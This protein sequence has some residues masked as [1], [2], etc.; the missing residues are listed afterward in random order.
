MGF[1]PLQG[2][3]IELEYML[4]DSVTL[5]V[6]PL[7]DKIFTEFT[8]CPTNEVEG[9]KLNWSN[10]LVRHVVELKNP[11]P[12]TQVRELSTAFPAEIQK[13]WKESEKMGCRLLATAM[14]PWMS[15]ETETRLWP[16]EQ[17]QIYETYDRIFHCQGHGW[18]N[19]QSSHINFSFGSTDEEFGNAH[20]VLRVVTSLVPLIASSSPYQEGKRGPFLSTR[21]FHY[22]QNQRRISSIIGPI[23]PEPIWN[24]KDYEEKIL[25]PMYREIAPLDTEGVLQEEWLNSRAVIPK[26][27]YN[28]FEVR[29]MDIQECPQA[30]LAL[31]WFFVQLARQLYVSHWVDV[32]LLK[33]LSSEELRKVLMEAA[34][35]ADETIIDN[36]KLLRV[37]G[38]HNPRILGIELLRH[39]LSELTY[40]PED[41][42][43]FQVCEDIFKRGP[44]SRCMVRALGEA[45][46]RDALKEF[47]SVL[48]KNLITN[49]IYNE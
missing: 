32:E 11:K 46:S 28:R 10:E 8:G 22:F 15:P 23:I 31:I 19:L 40:E 44:L 33:E 26:Y 34:E 36:P 4:V 37:F 13:L 47:Y 20:A 48:S 38:I 7:A 25:Q 24:R 42:A 21:L 41:E 12:V 9:D 18:A 16:L 30:D 49:Q 17:K 39:L 29:V 1:G 27:D 2:L 6:A 43:L 14:H 35:N 5:N 3:G 45:P